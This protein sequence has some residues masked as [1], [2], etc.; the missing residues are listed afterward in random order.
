ME[1]ETNEI[2]EP[3]TIES[4][5]T[6]PTRQRKVKITKAG[7]IINN[8]YSS[9]EA[10]EANKKK[11][12]SDHTKAANTQIITQSPALYEREGKMKKSV[13]REVQ[14][15]VRSELY[16]TDNIKKYIH[17]FITTAVKEPNSRAAIVLA[18]T[19]FNPDLLNQMDKELNKEMDQDISFKEYCIRKTLYDKQ[20]EVFDNNIDKII[21][22]INSRRSGKTELMGRLL[23]KRLVR[24]GQHCVYINRSFDAAI[25]QISQPL[26]TSLNAAGLT[27]KGTIGGGKI[28]FDN[29]SWLLIIGNNNVADVN[30]LRGERLSLVILDECGHMRNTRQLIQEVIQPATIDYADSQ[31][32]FVGTPPRTKINYMQELWDNP[33]IKHYHWTFE[34][35]PFIPNKEKVIEE[36]CK[37]HNI[38]KDDPFIQRE[39]YGIMGA[40]DTNAEIYHGYKTVDVVPSRTWTHAW[41]GVDWGFE[42]RAAVV[43]M[44]ADDRTKEAYVVKT[45]TASHTGTTETCKEV[46]A[47]YDWLKETYH[48]SREPWVIVD[49]NDKQGA[50]DLISIYKI[51]NTYCAYKYNL[52]NSIEELADW[53]RVGRI[54]VYKKENE[55]LI[56]DLNN[57]LW[58]RDEE[59]EKIKYE[60]DDGVWHPNAADALRY[61]SR[62]FAYDIL[63]TEYKTLK[64]VVEGTEGTKY[65]Y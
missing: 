44:V 42:D 5:E 50:A 62:C 49:T 53:L 54:K 27:Y 9:E 35:N 36:V 30:K 7:T 17:N 22:V 25:R 59:T 34:D 40:I 65:T 58:K 32:V 2:I 26:E 14:E 38:S 28:D 20:Q 60:V 24:P 61:I 11:P 45:W 23:A 47:M 63:R 15:Y 3:S 21:Q 33:Q 55:G 37:M 51:K 6:K 10:I 18:G 13:R 48:I 29:G 39:Y 52:T 4:T 41:I 16:D 1:Q 56:E 8:A 46:R 31:M 43:A 19:V 12:K 64:N 57:T